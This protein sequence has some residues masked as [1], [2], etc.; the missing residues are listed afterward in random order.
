[1]SLLMAAWKQLRTFCGLGAETS[2]LW[3]RWLVLRAVGVVYVIIFAG[4]LQEGPGLVGPHGLVQIDDYCTLAREVLPDVFVRILRVP[5]LFLIGSGPLAVATLQ[6]CGLAAAIALVLNLWPRFALFT[7]WAV[8]L[9]F[10]GVWREFSSTLNDPLMLE[11]ALLCIPF[12]PAGFRPGLGVASPPRPV[13]ILMMRWLLIRIMLTAGL[14]KLLGSDPGWRDFT[15]M[16][17][18]YETSPAPT[19]LA[20]HVYHLPRA[21]HVFEIG[22]TF[23]AE[24]LAPVL[25]I[26][27]GRRGRAI[28]VA[29]WTIFQLGIQLTG[30]F[31][32]LNTAAM[33]LGLLLLDDQMIVAA[34]R[35]FRFGELAE[36]L[37]TTARP[38]PL[39]PGWRSVVVGLLL[40]LHLGL[41]I[42][43]TALILRGKLVLGVPNPHTEPIQFLFRDLRSANCYSLYATTP[44]QR[45]EVEFVGSNDGGATWRPYPFRYKPQQEDRMSPFLAPRFGRFEATLQLV[46]DGGYQVSLIPDVARELVRG[47]PAVTDLFASNPFPD[48]PPTIVR[49]M[50][51]RYTFTDRKTQRATGRYWS[52]V[53]VGDYAP[54]VTADER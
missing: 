5:S 21:Y 52:K 41:A 1:M 38:M 32:W 7:C 46:L 39:L 11:T 9:S 14:V 17:R 26:F 47:N 37:A 53:Y 30:N 43:F 20:Y 35:R 3:P 23:A 10:V 51:Y 27:G 22:F 44:P 19:I 16:E 42:Y 25:A 48:A 15:F 36:R 29:L 24:L 18:M 6:W 34:C 49:M 8:L 33:A 13:T 2:H 54:P 50:G 40:W 4:I 31:A 28:A 45:I 12:A